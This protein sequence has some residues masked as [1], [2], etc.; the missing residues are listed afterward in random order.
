ML[1]CPQSAKRFVWRKMV[2]ICATKPRLL[3]LNM[4]A[5]CG[6]HAS[7]AHG[8]RSTASGAHHTQIVDMF[9]V[10]VRVARQA[11]ALQDRQHDGALG[12]L[13]A[14][15]RVP[16]CVRTAVQCTRAAWRRA[17]FHSLAALRPLQGTGAARVRRRHASTAQ[18]NTRTS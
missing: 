13:D 6:G 12:R 18:H 17:S 11:Q 3:S 16:L 15:L 9:L 1:P 4:S 10:P 2:L 14:D 8:K 5:C 7:A